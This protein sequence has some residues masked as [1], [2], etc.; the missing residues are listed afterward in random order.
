[1][2]VIAVVVT[3]NRK[4]LLVACLD[5]ALSQTRPVDHLLLLDNA[6][7]DGTEELLRAGGYLDR[8]DVEYVRSAENRGSSGG[9]A[10]AVSRARERD[11]DWLWLMDDDSQPTPEVLA[12]L[13]ASAPASDPAVVSLCPK[14]IYPGGGIDLNQR[15]D[16]RG[17]LRPLDESEYRPGNH[18][19]LGFLSFVG[20]LVRT[21]A[22]RGTDPPKA[23]FFVW[24][25]D[26]EYSFRLR[27]LGR[28]VLVPEA[29]MVHD[30]VSQSYMNARARFW[31][32]V[33]P[34][35]FF[36]TP[37]DRFWQ[38]LCGLRNYIWMKRE[39]EGQSAVG[40]WGTA[41]QFVAKHMLYDEQPFRRVP[42]I[43]RFARQGVQG[44][45]DNIPPGQWKAMVE[46]GEV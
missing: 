42:W 17:R 1:V 21:A 6:S 29:V 19:E 22:A 41:L 14:V 38:N 36:P 8:P 7:T 20:A 26:V 31:N 37:L 27:R 25:D 40:S 44:R 24:G 16:F 3:Y 9:F 39:Y 33:L 35:S 30:R 18:R 43:L 23:E 2:K 46:R 12:T 15:G 32:R 13:L 4:D 45:F 28:I 34:L 10:D 11:S 5:A